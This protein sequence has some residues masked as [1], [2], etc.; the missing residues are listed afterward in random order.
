MKLFAACAHRIGFLRR[1]AHSFFPRPLRERARVRGIQTTDAPSP[2]SSP[3]EGEEVKIG[4]RFVLVL[5][6]ISLLAA[7]PHDLYAAE[8][9]L[10]VLSYPDRP[11]KLPLWLAQDA[12][13]FEKYGLKVDIRSAESRYYL[14]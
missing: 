5:V 1:R 13:L 9:S 12:G 2:Q 3:V 11:A 8:N 4:S 7:C 10:T 14:V 6:T